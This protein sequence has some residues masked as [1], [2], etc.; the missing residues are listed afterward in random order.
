MEKAQETYRQRARVIDGVLAD[1]DHSGGRRIPAKWQLDIELLFGSEA[2]F[3]LALYPRWFAALSARLDQV[4]EDLPGDLPDAAGR[5]A[6][7][8][9]SER[10][11]LFTLLALHSGDP[12]L[13]VIHERELRS[14]RWAPA[15]RLAAL[16][17]NLPQGELASVA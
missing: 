1:I 10:P 11:E 9:A 15:A 17:A 14:L 3:A 5:A 16:A 13:E 7:S 4:L 2:G 12:E 8:L 6:A